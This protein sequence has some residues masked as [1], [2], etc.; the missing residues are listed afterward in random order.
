MNGQQKYLY[1]DQVN[2]Q[3][4]QQND[5]ERQDRHASGKMQDNKYRYTQG[6]ALVTHSHYNKS[7]PGQPSSLF[8]HNFWTNT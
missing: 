3:E 4:Q 5:Q 7:I 1:G 2:E 6:S 8:Q